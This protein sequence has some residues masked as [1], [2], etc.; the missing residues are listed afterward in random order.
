[1]E[2]P[3]YNLPLP[4]SLWYKRRKCF[5]LLELTLF[6]LPTSGFIQ[7]DFSECSPIIPGNKDLTWNDIVVCA[8]FL[9]NYTWSFLKQVVPRREPWWSRKRK[10]SLLFPE[11][12]HTSCLDTFSWWGGSGRGWGSGRVGGYIPKCGQMHTWM[13]RVFKPTVGPRWPATR[14][15]IIS[16][17]HDAG[18]QNSPCSSGSWKQTTILWP[19][20]F[21][22]EACVFFWLDASHARFWST[23]TPRARHSPKF[24]TPRHKKFERHSLGD[25]RSPLFWCTWLIWNTFL[26]LVFFSD[27]GFISG[28]KVCFQGNDWQSDLRFACMGLCQTRTKRCRQKGCLSDA[29][30][31]VGE[32]AQF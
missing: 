4:A 29:T 2:Q 30:L 17:L 6:S 19:E 32:N 8:H 27:V 13:L 10:L 7:H 16:S 21:A 11:K 23:Y 12:P 15:S 3:P 25:W 28:K 24:S 31:D 26:L 5:N 14:P 18:V 1:M 9:P 20:V 22:V